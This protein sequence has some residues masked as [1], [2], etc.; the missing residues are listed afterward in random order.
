MKLQDDG[1]YL[2]TNN[3]TKELGEQ[4]NNFLSIGFNLV[5]QPF[6]IYTKEPRIYFYQAVIRGIPSC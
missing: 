2:L 6:A 5:G 4:V 3:T 1:Y